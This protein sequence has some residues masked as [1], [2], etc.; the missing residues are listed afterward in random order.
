MTHGGCEFFKIKRTVGQVAAEV[1][2]AEIADGC[3]V[4]R[5]DLGDLGAEIREM[6]GVAR[7]PGLVALQVAGVFEN[8][9]SVTGFGE[10]AHHAR[11]EITRL[12]LALIELLA[13]RFKVGLFEGFAVEVGQ[14]RH[15]FGIEERPE[16]IPVSA[17]HEENRESSWPD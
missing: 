2:G 13:F 11:V 6:H 9:P 7:L 4:V 15:I 3:L 1:D 12:H 10:S 16:S 8:H 17:A 14:Q 5:G